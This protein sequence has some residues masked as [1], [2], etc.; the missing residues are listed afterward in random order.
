MVQV[1]VRDKYVIDAHQFVES[2]IANAGTGINQHI[3]IE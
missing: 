3:I 1:R 2:K